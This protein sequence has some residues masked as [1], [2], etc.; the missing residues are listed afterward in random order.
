[1]LLEFLQSCRNILA[2]YGGQPCVATGILNDL[3]GPA[4]KVHGVGKAVVASP[5]R[6]VLTVHGR[7]SGGAKPQAAG[8]ELHART[9][10]LCLDRLANRSMKSA[11]RALEKALACYVLD[12][13]GAYVWLVPDGYMA[14]LSQNELRWE[15]EGG[16]YFS[17]ES[18]CV[19][20]TGLRPT[21]CELTVYFEAP[22]PPHP[23]LSPL[24]RGKGEGGVAVLRHA[25]AVP[26]QRSIHLRLDKIPGLRGRPFIP[27]STPVGYKIVS[28]DAPVVVQGS[29][30]LT[31]GRESEFASFGTTM[32]WTPQ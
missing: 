10:D 28:L 12:G 14:A 23:T 21:R 3:Y 29:R 7:L 27:K 26:A 25:F 31:S 15:R 6:V 17:H 20:N 1:M 30:I 19:Q 18:M 22:R 2:R 8:L 4:L 13:D 9:I 5:T 24:G 32:A 16:G 11:A